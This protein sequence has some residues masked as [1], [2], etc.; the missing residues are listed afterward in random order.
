MPASNPQNVTANH[1]Q[2]LYVIRSGNGFSCLGFDVAEKRRKAYLRWLGVG[3]IGLETI[4]AEVGDVA[5]YAAYLDAL[6]AV[7]AECRRSG[8]R[9]EVELIPALIPYE[10]S[11]V[12]VSY[13]DGEGGT[14]RTRFIVGK[15]TGPIPI[16]LEIKRRDSS[17]G[18]GAYVP[19]GATVRPV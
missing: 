17:G 12:E 10:G 2:R 8:R 14:Y 16:H 13:P 15:S 11:R 18:C 5:A 9:C 19:E 6:D 7:L 3:D 4:G 1:D